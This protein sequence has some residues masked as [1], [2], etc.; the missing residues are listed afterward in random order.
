LRP[1]HLSCYGYDKKTSPNIDALAKQ[2][3][4]FTSAFSQAPYT[5]PSVTSIFTSVYPYSHQVMHILKDKVPDKINT[6]AQVLNIYGYR[7][8]WFGFMDDPHLGAAPGLLKGFQE[9]YDIKKIERADLPRYEIIFDW[10]KEHR[11][12]PFLLSV[13]SYSAHEQLFPF[14]RF[15]NKFSRDIPKDFLSFMDTLEQRYWNRLQNTLKNNPER[16]SSVLGKEWVEKN[17][18]YLI[19]PYSRRLLNEIFGLEPTLEHRVLIEQRWLLEG[20]YG[21]EFNNF[22]K[23]F[24]KKQLLC[25]LSLLDSAIYEFDKDMIGMLLNELKQLKIYDKTLIIVTAD[26]GN[27]YNEHG[28]FFHGSALYDEAIHVPLI[29]HAPKL[30]KPKVIKELVQSIDI[31]PTTLDLLS[32]PIPHQAQ[33][34]SLAGVMEGRENALTNEYVFCQGLPIGSLAM[35]SK[36]FKFIQKVIEKKAGT[37]SFETV[38]FNLK[39]DL[40]ESHDVIKEMPEAAELLKKRLYS[41]MDSLIVYQESGN[42]FIPGLSEETKERIKKTGYW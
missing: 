16:I 15:N 39:A 27:E 22:L 30:K 31:L 2:G 41:W 36:Y 4:L 29:F 14:K 3:V 5:L 11:K 23:S 40:H 35:R 20:I 7:T 37:D 34:I 26:H 21:Y 33:G 13:H 10:V 19:Q 1:D 28:G 17:T 8:V 38:L 24:D 25:F 42:E 12:E 18:K 6:L 32:I 9:K